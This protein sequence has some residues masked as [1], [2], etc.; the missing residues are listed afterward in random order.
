MKHLDED[1]WWAKIIGI[2]GALLIGYYVAVPIGHWVGDRFGE[3]IGIETTAPTSPG[4][5]HPNSTAS[6]P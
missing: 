2:I 6:S 4:S 3:M 5:P 1:P